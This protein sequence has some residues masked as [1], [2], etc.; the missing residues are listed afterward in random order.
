MKTILV[1][2]ETNNGQ[3]DSVLGSARLLAQRFESTIEGVALRVPQVAVVG[4]D[5]VVTVTFPPAEQDDREYVAATRR[6]F[7][8]FFTS[9]PSS[10]GKFT[11]RWRVEDP[12]DDVRLG[13]LAR[14]YDIT[15]AGRPQGSAAS[16][17]MAT[18]ES[19]LFESGRPVL[20]TPPAAPNRL[21]ECIVIAWNRSTE[22]ART[23]AYGLPLLVQAREVTVLTI[24]TVAVPGPSGAEVAGYLAAHGIKARELTMP[25][26]GRKSGEA[27]LAEA[28]KLGADLVFKG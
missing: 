13:S 14:V 16:P 28:A 26:Q 8:T 20:M 7:E 11:Y 5:P 19:A 25:L 1:P 4:P 6:A 15:I 2:I 24:E 23:V 9:Q 21:G 18:L 3:L 22:S 12:I 27:M 10:V 17:R